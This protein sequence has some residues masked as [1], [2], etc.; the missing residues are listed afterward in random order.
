MCL[1]IQF[2]PTAANIL[3]TCS[4]DSL[5]NVFDTSQED[6]DETLQFW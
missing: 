2:H 3:A 1:Q 5:I 6:E 4:T